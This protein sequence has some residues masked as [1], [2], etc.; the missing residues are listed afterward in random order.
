MEPKKKIIHHDIS[1]RPWDVVGAD[2]FHINNKNDLC[3]IDYHSKYLVV[4]KT[5]AL[6]ADSLITAF[7]VVFQNTGY[8]KK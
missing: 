6:S 3:I 5:E 4:K 8:H 7:K 1:I 2:M